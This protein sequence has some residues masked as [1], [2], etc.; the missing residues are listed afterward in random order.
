MHLYNMTANLYCKSNRY[1]FCFLLEGNAL[2]LIEYEVV[3]RLMEKGKG[4]E[5]QILLLKGTRDR[6]GIRQES[7]NAL[8]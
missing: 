8:F 2:H 1:S 4:Q 6:L 7:E 5:E 3:G